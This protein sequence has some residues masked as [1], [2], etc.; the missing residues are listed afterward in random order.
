MQI[1]IELAKSA[2][3]VSRG[4]L[5]VYA[6]FWKR[7]AAAWIDCLVSMA[8]W[9][10]YGYIS[11]FL[12][13]DQLIE[14]AIAE[15]HMDPTALKEKI[16]DIHAESLGYGLVF[17]VGMTWIYYAVF[18]ASR[19]QATLGKLAVGI[20]VTDVHGKRIGFGK[21]SGRY[22]SK[23][24]S[25]TIIGIGY[26][27]AAFTKRKQGLHDMMAGC[28]VISQDADQDSVSAER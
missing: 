15:L 28:L 26:L 11:G 18:E 25:A 27:M 22:F 4:I 13:V 23:F 6:G 24:I 19:K 16:N 14:S 9:M 17:S 20:K 12:F 21:A 3:I 2:P 7:L 5:M 10:I 8:I 1:P